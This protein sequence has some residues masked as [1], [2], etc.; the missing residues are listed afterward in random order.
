MPKVVDSLRL[1]GELIAVNSNI[2]PDGYLLCN[3]NTLGSSSSGAIFMGPVYFDLFSFLWS[4]Y[5]NTQL[6]ILTSTGAISTRASSALLDW[7]A[8]K[9]MPLPNLIGRTLIGAGFYTDIVSGSVTRNL[10]DSIGAEAH[11]LDPSQ[12][13][14]HNHNPAVINIPYE[15]GYLGSGDA[16]FAAGGGA[17]FGSNGTSFPTANA[18]GGLSHN[19]M[20][21]S[22]VTNWVIKF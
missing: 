13:P 20:Q 14:S 19:N 10:G 12:M 1:I 15:S 5:S 18:G 3:G 22:H 11:V 6:G 8:N 17:L 16:A 4:N 7:G 21:P 2:I 9:R